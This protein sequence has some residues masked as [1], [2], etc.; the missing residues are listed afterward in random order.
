[1]CGVTSDKCSAQYQEAKIR[2]V[3]LIVRLCPSHRG[4]KI[5]PL[6][7]V[8]FCLF[9]RGTNLR[10]PHEFTC[11]H[12]TVGIFSKSA[13]NTWTN[14][15][16]SCPII[17]RCHANANCCVLCPFHSFCPPK[18]TFIHF[19]GSSPHHPVLARMHRRSRSVVRFAHCRMQKNASGFEASSSAARGLTILV[20]FYKCL[21]NKGNCSMKKVQRL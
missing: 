5:W 19:V 11:F 14:E 12:Q 2:T 6:G 1:M 9:I 7:L 21:L 4:R 17:A 20:M 15:R 8:N 13:P 10:H 18:A 16:A 3:M